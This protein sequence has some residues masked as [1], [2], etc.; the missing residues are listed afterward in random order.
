ML[1]K[2]LGEKVKPRLS[3]VVRGVCLCVCVSISKLGVPSQSLVLLPSSGPSNDGRGQEMI[4]SPRGGRQV[5]IYMPVE[6][7][8]IPPGRA[9]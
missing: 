3:S 7:I 6:V 5:C 8:H 2:G 1:W 4:R 9:G